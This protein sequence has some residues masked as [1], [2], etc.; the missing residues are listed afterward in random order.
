MSVTL[1]LMA[2]PGRI[3]C[4]KTTECSE[5]DSGRHLSPNLGG[6]TLYIDGQEA[7]SCRSI[8]DNNNRVPSRKH[9]PR[10]RLV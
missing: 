10:S 6:A 8:A 1:G 3:L 5:K 2:Y 9:F 7:N 4:I